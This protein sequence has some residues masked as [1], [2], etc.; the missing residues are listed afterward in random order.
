[1]HLAADGLFFG[2]MCNC[3][4]NIKR[5]CTTVNVWEVDK[6][7]TQNVPHQLLHKEHSFGGHHLA[8]AGRQR[9]WVRHIRKPQSCHFPDA[10]SKVIFGEY[11]Q[12][13]IQQHL[14]LSRVVAAV[15]IAFLIQTHP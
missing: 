1:M 3:E 13:R 6:E 2:S 10:K 12:F 11:T 5:R 7:R 8:V 4:R 14:M 9:V 15:V